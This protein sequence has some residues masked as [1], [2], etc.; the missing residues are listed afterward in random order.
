MISRFID[1][2]RLTGAAPSNQEPRKF[3]VKSKARPLNIC[4][5]EDVGYAPIQILNHSLG[6]PIGKEKSQ[7]AFVSNIR[8]AAA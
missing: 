3:E 6:V 5:R 1:F 2:L 7:A 4:L 8:I